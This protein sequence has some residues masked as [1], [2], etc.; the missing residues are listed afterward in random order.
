MR[1]ETDE[2]QFV[3]KDFD[4]RKLFNYILSDDEKKKLFKN[5]KNIFEKIMKT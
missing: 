4:E 5:M 2:K 1:I 3:F